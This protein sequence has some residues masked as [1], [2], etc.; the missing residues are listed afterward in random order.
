MLIK[1]HQNSHNKTGLFQI[2]K[3]ESKIMEHS[4]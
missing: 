3:Q 2:K 1:H 4:Y